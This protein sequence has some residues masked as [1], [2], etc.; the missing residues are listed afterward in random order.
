M[1][2][3]RVLPVQLKIY[4]TEQSLRQRCE[5]IIYLLVQK[6]CHSFKSILTLLKFYAIMY[7]NKSDNRE[8]QCILQLS[9]KYKL[10]KGIVNV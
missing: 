9:V 7:L 3:S 1:G 5:T 8:F 10:Q 2:H 4:P 6:P